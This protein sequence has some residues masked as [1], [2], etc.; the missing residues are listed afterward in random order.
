MYVKPEPPRATI[1]EA[2]RTEVDVPRD[3]D[4]PVVARL[5]VEIR[6]D[7]TRT[8][9]R[10]AL[11]DRALGEQVALEVRAGTPV[12]LA[13]S[14]VKLLLKAPALANMAMQTGRKRQVDA[15]P[16]GERPGLVARVRGAAARG[17]RKR[18]GLE[19]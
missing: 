3:E 5:V 8:V 13:A 16:A 11:E 15:L 17:L 1:A 12:E 7:G 2:T 10:G 14:L 4:L 9:A 19:D 6:S 18:L